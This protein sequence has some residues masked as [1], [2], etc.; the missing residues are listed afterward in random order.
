MAASVN[1]PA[2]IKELRDRLGLSQ[3]KLAAR[4]RVSLPTIN[5]WEKGKTKP[6]AMAL[7]AIEQFLQR[8]GE[9]YH[10]LYEH[11][12]AVDKE[13]PAARGTVKTLAGGRRAAREVNAR[14]SSRG[15]TEVL[16]TKS[17]EGLLW[18]AA[19]S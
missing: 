19:C 8:L 6:D 13:A 4:L 12:F 14:E 17:M 3:E 9:E 11:Y 2:L 16:D 7:H 18:K 10:D 1:V 5:R 15:S